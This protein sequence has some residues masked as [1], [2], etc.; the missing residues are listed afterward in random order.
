ADLDAFQ[1]EFRAHVERRHRWVF[2]DERKYGRLLRCDA[3]D[4]DA[5]D[6][7]HVLRGVAEQALFVDGD[8][9]QADQ[10]YVIDGRPEADRAGDVGRAGFEL[11]RQVGVDRFLERNRGNHVAAALPGRHRFQVLGLA[12]EDAYAG[13]AV[14]LVTAENEEVAI[15]V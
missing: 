12:V 6:L 10:L 15:E 2:D 7:P 8:I 14:H 1:V 3:D 11:V 5:G 13:R 9:L 4:A